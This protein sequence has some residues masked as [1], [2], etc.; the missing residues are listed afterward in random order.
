M[1]LPVSSSG[2]VLVDSTGAPAWSETIPPA[3]TG[4]RVKIAPAKWAVELAADA[5]QPG[6]ELERAGLVLVD[7]VQVGQYPLVDRAVSL[8]RNRKRNIYHPT[9][10]HRL[11]YSG[12]NIVGRSEDGEEI[13]PR[14]DPVVIGLVLARVDSGPAGERMLL[15]RNVAH[16]FFSIPAGYVEVG[17][18]L[19]E[20]FA[21]EVL[22]ETGRRIR[23]IAYW[24]SQPWSLSGAIM[25]AFIS[26]TEDIDKVSATDGE[27]VEL[28]WVS[29][30]ELAALPAHALPME[31]SIALR[32]IKA[33]LNGE[34]SA[35]A[36]SHSCGGQ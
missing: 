35:P 13:F 24:G 30:Q 20:A 12:G 9:T 5:L 34:V 33:W 21:R 16:D 10:G 4:L 17:E 18:S 11:H 7:P 27:L 32:L 15:G 31:G 6:S 26:C 2:K 3:T 29:R 14:L 36:C 1:F 19:E 28:H 22:E 23:Q 25:V 8:L